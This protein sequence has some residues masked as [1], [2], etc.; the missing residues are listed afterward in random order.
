[1]QESPLDRETTSVPRWVWSLFLCPA[2]GRTT[3]VGFRE[4]YNHYAYWGNGGFSWGVLYITGLIAMALQINPDLTEEEAFA[5]LHAS[6][7]DHL[8]G[9]FVN[10]KGFLER[11]AQAANQPHGGV[12]LFSCR[13]ALWEFRQ[14]F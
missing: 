8:G 12:S 6:S 10:P 7:H 13:E 3:A 4:D 1:M 2:D 11:V 9:N 14:L 5:Y